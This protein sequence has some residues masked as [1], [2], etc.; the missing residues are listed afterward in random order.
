MGRFDN[1]DLKLNE[2]RMILHHYKTV[3]ET[4]TELKEEIE[5]NEDRI[6]D[7]LA[8]DVAIKIVED[9]ITSLKGNKN[10]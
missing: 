5:G 3:K 1:I 4:L 9:K 10:E 7:C 6:E 8:L 2:K